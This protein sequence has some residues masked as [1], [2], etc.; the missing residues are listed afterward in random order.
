MRSLRSISPRHSR[1][2]GNPARLQPWIPAFAGMTL[3]LGLLTSPLLASEGEKPVARDYSLVRAPA[4]PR[5]QDWEKAEA[6]SAGC[7]SCHTDSDR[8]TMHATPAVVLGCTDCHGGD[9]AVSRDSSLTIADPHYT[10]LRDRAHVLPKYPKSWHWPS[11]A[12]PPRSYTLLNIESPEYVRFVNPSD[13]R[14]AR[15][16]CGACH[17]ET[18][19]AAERSLMA[20]GA[21]LWGGAAYNN[22]ILP[23]KNYLFG[24]AYTRRGEPAK[25]VSPP[26]PQA[27]TPEQK[28]RGVLAELYP[29]PTWHVVPP[30]DVFRVFERGGPAHGSQFP[31]VCLPPPPA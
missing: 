5:T 24:E 3:A 4:A 22:G 25:I 16:S 11:S 30:G 13:Y 7:V 26:S 19:E 31:A 21:M 1:E 10:A 12:N 9:A 17:I 20:S 8:K 28:A 15:D 18:I 2:S 23:Y 14:V 6:K 27:V 29:L